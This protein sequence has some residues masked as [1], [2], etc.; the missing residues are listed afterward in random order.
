MDER[1]NAPTSAR[2]RLGGRVFTVFATR[3]TR[4]VFGRMPFRR[5]FLRFQKIVYLFD[6]FVQLRRVLLTQHFP[7]SL[8]VDVYSV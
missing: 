1:L 6:E 7:A 8:V 3:I 2:R 4:Y 5:G